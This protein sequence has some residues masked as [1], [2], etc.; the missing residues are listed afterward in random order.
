MKVLFRLATS[1]FSMPPVDFVRCTLGRDEDGDPAA[2]LAKMP[3]KDWGF[4]DMC[5]LPELTKPAILENLKER[6]DGELVYTYVGDIVCSVNPF[7]N[8]GCVGKAIRARYRGAQRH[9]LPPHIYTLVDVCYTKMMKEQKSPRRRGR[10]C[11]GWCTTTGWR[12]S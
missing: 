6:F 4:S 11:G 7:K 2:F 10:S 8:V 12:R 3:K 9:T 1:R 5:E